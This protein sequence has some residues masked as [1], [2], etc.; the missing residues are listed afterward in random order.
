[1]IN[2]LNSFFA[3]P[4]QVSFTSVP[5]YKLN[6]PKLNK[7]SYEL[8]PILFSKLD[9]SDALDIQM[10]DACK[11]DFSYKVEFSIP[12]GAGKNKSKNLSIP[13]LFLNKCAELKNKYNFFAL[14]LPNVAEKGKKIIALMATNKAKNSLLYRTNTNYIEML[15]VRTRLKNKSTSKKREYKNVGELMI[16]GIGKMSQKEGSSVSLVSGCNEFYDK[17]GMPGKALRK[18]A[19]ND[20]NKFLKRTE[21]KFE[22]KDTSV[23]K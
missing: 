20:L 21:D 8:T 13:E 16:Y 23:G 17:I 3:S 2:S 19:G 10:I 1:M 15:N 5:V 6:I 7:G 12:N 18:F 4:K 22:L 9:T 14:E 11:K